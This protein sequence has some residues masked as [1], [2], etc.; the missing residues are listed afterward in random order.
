MK[1]PFAVISFKGKQHLVAVGDEFTT[2]HLDQEQSKKL[3]IT[4]VLLLAK[5]K[6]TTIGQPL[7]DKA[8][9]QLQVV[10]H[11]KSPK[12]RVAKFRAKSRYRRVKGHRQHQTTLKVAAI[13]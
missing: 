5:D 9:V 7:I 6:N 1:K 2:D 13:K 12:I 8:K 10:S 3:D 4:D 11:Q